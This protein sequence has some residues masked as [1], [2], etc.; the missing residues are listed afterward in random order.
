MVGHRHTLP[1][2]RGDGGPVVGGVEPG[3]G[4]GVEQQPRGVG[5]HVGLH[6]AGE[7]PDV[8]A[9][10]P[11]AV[12]PGPAGVVVQ[13]H[14]RPGQAHHGVVAQ[15]G[16]GAVRGAAGGGELEPVNALVPGDEPVRGGLGDQQRA[17]GREVG[18]AER[19]RPGAPGLLPRGEHH[20]HATALVRPPR[21]LGG[22]DDQ[23][24]TPD[25][26]SLVPRPSTRSPSRPALHG[27]AAHAAGSPVGTVSRWP[28]R[29]SGAS[30]DPCAPPAARARAPTP[31][32]PR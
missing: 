10:G 5:H 32:W 23:A 20:L 17:A 1:G 18:G 15:L 25:F 31:G 24:A 3:H 7:H 11:E 6:P 8:G 26:M 9:D 13:R 29:V 14:R 30:P 16:G 4:A 27:S 2:E 12:V 28:V 21:V 19:E 22:G